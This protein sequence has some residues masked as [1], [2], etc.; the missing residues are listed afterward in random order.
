MALFE[1]AVHTERNFQHHQIVLGTMDGNPVYMDFTSH[2]MSAIGSDE[3]RGYSSEKLGPAQ[4]LEIQ[5]AKEYAEFCRPGITAEN[6]NKF[7]TMIRNRG[8]DVALNKKK[9]P[10]RGYSFF[11]DSSKKDEKVPA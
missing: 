4:A 11:M 3:R 2:M 5:R 10:V 7:N 9:E 6:M 1:Y 8:G